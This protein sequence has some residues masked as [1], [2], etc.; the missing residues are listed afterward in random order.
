MLPK[1]FLALATPPLI[2]LLGC[3]GGT[4]AASSQTPSGAAITCARGDGSMNEALYGWGFCYPGTW[5]FIERGGQS[6][7]PPGEDSTF[8]ITDD[9]PAG[10]PQRGLFGFMIV[11][12][13]QRGSSP[14]LDQWLTTNEGAN[15]VAQPILWGNS[16]AA[17][18][19]PA[20]GTRYALTPHHV[21]ALQLRQGAGN[22]DLESAMAPRLSTWRFSY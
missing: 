18:Y 11:S 19:V 10:D 21:V 5:R 13:Y 2:A 9:G 3:G 14:T 1:R 4:P 7:G 6:L 17:V 12:T 15:L 8:D 16:E 20:L 22:L